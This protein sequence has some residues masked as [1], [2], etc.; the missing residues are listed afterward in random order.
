MCNL[1]SFNEVKARPLRKTHSHSTIA[2]IDRL[3]PRSARIRI[4]LL[5]RIERAVRRVNDRRH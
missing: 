2:R 1:Y 5:S 4:P 3:D